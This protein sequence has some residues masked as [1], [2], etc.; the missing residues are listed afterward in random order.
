MMPNLNQEP[1]ASPKAP[2]QDLRDMD[3]LRTLEIK[4]EN[5]NP[6]YWCIKKS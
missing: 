3:D 1:L 6:Q 2:N 5:Q 4:I